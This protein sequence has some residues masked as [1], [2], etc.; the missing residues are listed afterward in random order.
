MELGS[1][2]FAMT[3]MEME[4]DNVYSPMFKMKTTINITIVCIHDVVKWKRID[5]D[6][7]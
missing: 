3:E 5:F 6:V 7:K 2:Q 1:K 4:N